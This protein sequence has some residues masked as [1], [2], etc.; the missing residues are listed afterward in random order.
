MARTLGGRDP[1][2]AKPTKPKIVVFGKPGVGKTWASI[3]FPSVFYIDTEGGAN[4]EH[5]TDKLKTAGARYFGPED[6]S[7]DFDAVVEQIITLATIQH[8][9][10]TVVIDSFSKL[11]NATAAMAAERLSLKDGKAGDEFGRDKKEANKPTRKLINWITKLDMNVILICHEKTLWA[12]GEQVG[13]TPDMWDKIEYELDLVLSV[14]KQGSSRKAR[15]TKTRIEQFPDGTI[16]D[17]SFKEFAARYGQDIIEAAVTPISSASSDQVNQL[18]TL[19]EL[20][21]V[22]PD[23][24]EKWLTKAGVDGFEEMD[25]ETIQKCIDFLKNKL[26]KAA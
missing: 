19:V 4:R 26:P 22:T 16:F 5:Y 14:T 7:L 20:L 21:R 23:I 6:G 12:N 10:R 2:A 13:V 3:D 9:Y 15:V 11:Y 25:S 1:K 8:T 18:K 24:I 17:W